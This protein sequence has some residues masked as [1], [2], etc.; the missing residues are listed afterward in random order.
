[1]GLHLLLLLFLLLIALLGQHVGKLLS[2][3]VGNRTARIGL[4]VTDVTVGTGD[5]PFKVPT[6]QPTNSSNRSVLNAYQSL[7]VYRREIVASDVNEP[8][9]PVIADRDQPNKDQSSSVSVDES[10]DT[11]E[12]SALPYDIDESDNASPSATVLSSSPSQPDLDKEDDDMIL[13]VPSSEPIADAKPTPIVVDY[14]PSMVP[15][16]AV[17]PDEMIRSSPPTSVDSDADNTSV[18]ASSD[19]PSA[20]VTVFPSSDRA[21]PS[22]FSADSTVHTIEPSAVPLDIDTSDTASPS[23]VFPSSDRA[24]P[25][26]FSPDSTIDTLEPSAVPLDIDT[27]YTASPSTVFPSS[28]RASPSAAVLSSSPS[29]PGLDKEDDDMLMKVPSSEPIADANSTPIVIDYTPSMVPSIAVVP[30]E[31]IRS[32]PPASVDSDADNT[33][34]TASSDKPS[35]QATLMPSDA[36]V[37]ALPTSAPSITK[38]MVATLVPNEQDVESIDTPPGTEEE[39]GAGEGGTGDDVPTLNGADGFLA[40]LTDLQPFAIGVVVA[41]IAILCLVYRWCF[42]AC[43]RWTGAHEDVVQYSQVPQGDIEMLHSLRSDEAEEELWSEWESDNEEGNANAA[44]RSSATDKKHPDGHRTN[45]LST[46]AATASSTPV[47][48]DKISMSSSGSSRPF[49]AAAIAP[50]APMTSRATSRSKERKQSSYAADDVDLFEVS[51]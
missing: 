6:L 1:M 2:T 42:A 9:S 36:A 4:S 32:S 24:S 16:I 51:E 11:L 46:F 12:P 39:E 50:I 41:A 45:K 13:K 27:S 3:A 17:V 49:I 25:S 44:V 20:Q 40:Q 23:T 5:V 35:A 18:T 26:N 37:F 33:S 28:G 30:D 47:A 43:S 29:Q 31:M 21:S 48:A 14:T 15:S 34:V 19:K 7:S 10:Q 22:N 8:A 38:G